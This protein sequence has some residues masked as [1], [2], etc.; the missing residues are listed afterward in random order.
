M[1]SVCQIRQSNAEAKSMYLRVGLIGT[2]NISDIYLKNAPLFKSLKYVACADLRDEVAERQANKYGLRHDSVEG[3][4]NASDIDIALNLTVPAAHYEVSSSAIQSGKH[5]YSEKPLSTSLEDGRKLLATADHLG[6]RVGT[7][8]DIFLGPSIQ[9]AKSLVS[10]GQI[11]EVVSAVGSIMT[12]GMEHWHPNPTFFYQKGAGPVLDL[13][14]Y[15]IS[16][17]TVLLGPVR[18]VRAT[19]RI[20]SKER[21]ITAPGAGYGTTITVETL[22][23]V[24]ALLSFSSGAE[25]IFMASWDVWSH[26]MRPIEIYGTRGSIRVPN[27]NWFGGTVEIYRDTKREWESLEASTSRMAEPNYHWN[28]G[29]FANYRGAGLADMAQ[30]ILDDRPHRCSGRFAL[31]TLAVLAGIIESAESGRSIEIQDTCEI[32]TAITDAE[33]HSLFI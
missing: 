15:Y 25:A 17:L 33:A 12:R 4:L 13:G 3:L 18:C 28:G 1:K 31:H 5:A 7:A 30:A 20:G 32:P 27:P 14:P 16:A 29:Y 10:E 23:S 6:L 9:L 11:G 19:G 22:T 26:G 21:L 8:P 2:G 24:N